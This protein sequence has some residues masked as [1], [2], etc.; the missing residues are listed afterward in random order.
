MDCNES[1]LRRVVSH[2]PG[3]DAET[4]L[5]LFGRVFDPRLVAAAASERVR[6]VSTDDLYA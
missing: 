5:V 6:I 3:A 1:L 2:V 4:D